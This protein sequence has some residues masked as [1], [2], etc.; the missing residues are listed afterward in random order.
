MTSRVL[1]LLMLQSQLLCRFSA[2]RQHFES[3][4]PKERS[5]QL[6]LCE[7]IFGKTILHGENSPRMLV[8]RAVDLEE[9]LC[10]RTRSERGEKGCFV[11]VMWEREIGPSRSPGKMALLQDHVQDCTQ[12]ASVHLD[13]DRRER[14]RVTP[15]ASWA[16]GAPC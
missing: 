9:D 10:L 11:R 12:A 8:F 5:S 7:D 2:S 16:T 1:S 4:D 15:V 13:T 3:M 6:A 14:H